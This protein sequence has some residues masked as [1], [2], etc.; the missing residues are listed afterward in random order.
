MAYIPAAQLVDIEQRPGRDR[1]TPL[2]F[3]I[4]KRR[5]K[6][7]HERAQT[8]SSGSGPTFRRTPS[9]ERVV[10][11][12]KKA[13][14][15]GSSSMPLMVRKI[16]P[17]SQSNP[18]FDPLLL[19]EVRRS[20]A[21]QEDT[22]S[23]RKKYRRTAKPQKTST[24]F[25]PGE[26]DGVHKPKIGGMRTPG[27]TDRRRVVKKVVSDTTV[28]VSMTGRHPPP[29]TTAPAPPTGEPSSPAPAPPK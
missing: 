1:G 26:K 5:N 29:Q 27:V 24:L 19:Q 22:F 23:T 13:H 25:A 9:D 17:R 4:K 12:T 3:H 2:D 20:A 15:D 14:D 10:V 18:E 21:A 11:E 6:A 7:K 28:D 16:R 8:A